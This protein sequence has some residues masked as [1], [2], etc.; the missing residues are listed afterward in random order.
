MNS[1][2]LLGDYRNRL[3]SNLVGV[4]V[5]LVVSGLGV[6]KLLQVFGVID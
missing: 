3:A 5:V 1:K 2:P 4:L 6:Y